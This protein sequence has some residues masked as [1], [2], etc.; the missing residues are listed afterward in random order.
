M[1]ARPSDAFALSLNPAGL[2]DVPDHQLL[3]DVGV[4]FHDM[5]VTPYGYYGWG[6]YPPDPNDPT[7]NRSVFGDAS[8]VKRDAN[9]KPVIGG[10]YATD[11]LDRVCNS[12]PVG[13]V[14]SLAYDMHFGPDVGVAF[15]MVLPTTLG[16]LQYGGD[17]GTIQGAHGA[18][19]TPT[20]YQMV[21]QQ[22]TAGLAPS[23]GAG[24]RV[25]P[26][27]RV[28]LTFEWLGAAVESTV[29]QA[30]YAGASPATDMLVK[31][32]AHDFFM[33]AFTFGALYTPI[34]RLDLALTG[35]IADGFHGQGDAQY[36]TYAYQAPN[37][38]RVPLPNDLLRLPSVDTGLPW[39]FTAGIRYAEPLRGIEKD[40][41]GVA[42]RGDPLA[43]ERF[44]VELDLGYQM[45]ERAGK[46]SI[47]VDSGQVTFRQPGSAL[48][49]QD[50]KRAQF[51]QSRHLLD[52][53]TVRLG[54]TYNLVPKRFSV[55]AGTFYESRG[56]EAAYANLDAFAFARVGMGLGFTARVERWDFG[57]AYGHVFEETLTV[58]PGDQQAWQTVAAPGAVATGIDKRVGAPADAK[59]G[60]VLVEQNPPA[61]TKID[62]RA[63]LQQSAVVGNPRVVNAGVYE[64]SFNTLSGSVAYRF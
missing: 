58:A 7:G 46:T 5:C 37:A 19:P 47:I 21:K 33:P 34:D 44:D 24:V 32:R 43:T 53:V 52:A 27:W 59:S 17:N 50:I 57:L 30:L 49:H 41:R 9:G 63:R 54:G 29:A 45:N 11:P 3:L 40:S 14:P 6:V 13:A 61:A 31:V 62:A 25:A 39:V 35:R 55:N 38:P 12:A 10:S 26:R 18:R 36:T 42:R 56:V 2:A 4:P 15:G 51:D 64:A 28:G 23:I 1:V 48:L 60:T 8:T 16:S 20:R 22:V